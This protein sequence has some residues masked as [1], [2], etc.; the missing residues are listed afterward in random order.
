MNRD[1]DKF[2]DKF[3]VAYTLAIEMAV[4]VIV[5][6]LIGRWLD[7][8]TG[9]DP[10]FTIGGMI[11]GGAAAMRSAYRALTRMQKDRERGEQ[12]ERDTGKREK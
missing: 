4:A 12:S 3:G 11:L 8:K 6:V 2:V 10:W 1:R 9:K 5:P 7:G